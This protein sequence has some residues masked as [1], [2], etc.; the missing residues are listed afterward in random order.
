[1][2]AA[3][4]SLSSPSGVAACDL[5]KR[6]PGSP[7]R[8]PRVPRRAPDKHPP[9]RITP[10]NLPRVDRGPRPR[11][12]ERSRREMAQSA[13][14]AWS[15]QL[16]Q[17]LYC[18]S[19]EATQ[20]ADG[21]SAVHRMRRCVTGFPQ[22]P[23]P[24]LSLAT[25]LVLPPRG[26]EPE[27]RLITFAGG[28]SV[29]RG[30]F[31][32]RTTTLT[33][34]HSVRRRR[35]AA[36]GGRQ[37]RGAA[38]AVR[39]QLGQPAAPAGAGGGARGAHG[40]ARLLARDGSGARELALSQVGRSLFQGSSTLRLAA[41]PRL[42]V[43]AA[44]HGLA[45]W[46]PVAQLV[47]QLQ[48]HNAALSNPSCTPQQRAASLQSLQSLQGELYSRLAAASA[49]MPAE[50]QQSIA[51][52]LP[53]LPQASPAAGAAAGEL[54]AGGSIFQQP[55]AARVQWYAATQPLGAGTPLQPAAPGQPQD[56]QAAR[57]G[58]LVPA[59][60]PAA[61]YQRPSSSVPPWSQ[62]QLLRAA[63]LQPA[64]A[65]SGA[66]LLSGTSTNSNPRPPG[67]LGPEPDTLGAWLAAA[68]DPTSGMAAALAVPTAG[69][70]AAAPAPSLA[71]GLG[72]AGPRAA[73]AAAA[74]A[75]AVPAAPAAPRSAAAERPPGAAP[76]ISN[77]VSGSSCLCIISHFH[78]SLAA[79]SRCVCCWATV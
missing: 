77:T 30:P 65:A 49:S 63:A 26:G 20:L 43:G 53:L 5:A 74:A 55:A 40:Q 24:L 35:R 11:G 34:H 69:G 73:A 25:A 78:F 31:R 46:H 9:L 52:S 7:P 47:Q 29:A 15:P 37:P 28:W 1:M 70:Q 2:P 64:A 13:A 41:P 76:A 59:A 27:L 12:A 23:L 14:A 21:C 58:A 22:A 67:R 16:A 56:Q 62:Q 60:P 79:L 54:A 4:S 48:Q 51:A 50:L 68:V 19:A 75:A 18:T 45:T 33:T 57:V 3:A 17:M 8:A 32:R 10:T 61:A 71:G 72:L 36:A 66:E 42:Q 38:A 39:R 44:L 6:E